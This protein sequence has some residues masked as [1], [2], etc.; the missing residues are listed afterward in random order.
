MVQTI[1]GP[2]IPPNFAP[3]LFS[4]IV[5]DI[6]QFIHRNFNYR[7]TKTPRSLPISPALYILLHFSIYT[8][9]QRPTTLPR[10]AV[11]ERTCAAPVLLN[12]ESTRGLP[13]IILVGEED[14]LRSAS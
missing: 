10:S 1:S 4:S 3:S 9:S 13:L 14:N 2:K 6:I 5:S 8:P 7:C 11:L 12:I